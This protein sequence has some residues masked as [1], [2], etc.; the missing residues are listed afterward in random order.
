M[1]ILLWVGLPIVILGGGY[2]IVHFATHGL[3]HDT[4]LRKATSTPR[5]RGLATTVQRVPFQRSESGVP[6]GAILLE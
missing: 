4:R 6:V 5:G 1:P 2:A 3:V